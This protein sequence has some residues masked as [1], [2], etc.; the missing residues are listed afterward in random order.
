MTE[1]YVSGV[2]IAWESKSATDTQECN[3]NISQNENVAFIF[4]TSSHQSEVAF[5]LQENSC[6]CSRNIK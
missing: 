6:L 2:N 5:C 3:K 4:P 1:D